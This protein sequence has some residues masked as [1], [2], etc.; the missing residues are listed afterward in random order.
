MSVEHTL[1]PRS[2]IVSLYEMNKTSW[3]VVYNSTI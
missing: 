1:Y 2:L 3:P